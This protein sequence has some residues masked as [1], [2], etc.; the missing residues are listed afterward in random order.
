VGAHYTY[1]EVPLGAW[2]SE[3]L[4]LSRN[5]YD[6]F[7]HFAFGVLL[8]RPVRELAFPDERDPGRLRALVL[9]VAGV[10]ALSVGYEIVEWLTAAVVDPQAGTAFLGTQGDEWDAQKDMSLAAGGAVLAAAF[11]RRLRRAPRVAAR[12]SGREGTERSSASGRR[13]R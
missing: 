7:V 2:A 12:G 5:H 13:E 6:R 1:S 10:T 9:S 11:E 4:G 3:A 8:L